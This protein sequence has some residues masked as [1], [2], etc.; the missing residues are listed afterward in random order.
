MKNSNLAM[1]LMGT[2]KSLLAKS[3][4]SIQPSI[5]SIS[6]QREIF[7]Q[8]KFLGLLTMSLTTSLLITTSIVKPA[9]AATITGGLSY[10]KDGKT[11]SSNHYTGEYTFK[12]E[13]I[14]GPPE[15]PEKIKITQE[16][17]KAKTGNGSNGWLALINVTIDSDGNITFDQSDV[18]HYSTEKDFDKGK[19]RNRGRFVGSVDFDSDPKDLDFK[20]FPKYTRFPGSFWQFTSPVPDDPE[21]PPLEMFQ[22]FSS[23]APFVTTNETTSPLSF[24]TIGIG[25]TAL[26]LKNKLKQSQSSKK[27]IE[28]VS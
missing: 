5:L 3:A 21:D 9:I 14:P 25:C 12:V 20:Y 19:E 6:N 15:K 7:G 11:F 8:V 23:E 13:L 28:K 26:T 2:V 17:S 16:S 18:P 4:I 1:A 27:E 24:L 22:D 10:S